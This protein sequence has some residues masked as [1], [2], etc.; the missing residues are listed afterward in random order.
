MKNDFLMMSRWAESE[1]REG[2]DDDVKQQQ[3]VRLV[4]AVFGKL[5]NLTERAI[6]RYKLLTNGK[7]SRAF[8]LVQRSFLCIAR[9]VNPI[10]SFA[11]MK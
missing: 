2:T 4:R 3:H 6:R 1:Q 8:W 10:A 5:K 11:D 7:L 9:H